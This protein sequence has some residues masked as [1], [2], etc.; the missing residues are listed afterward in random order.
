MP[1]VKLE[2]P[3][4]APVQRV[5]DTVVDVEGYQEMMDHVRSVRLVE[6]LDDRVRHSE[7]SVLLKGSILEWLE[8]DRLD[9]EAHTIRFRQLSGDLEFFDGGWRLSPDGV[10]ATIVTFEVAFDIGIPSLASMLN[11][12]AERSLRENCVTMLQAIEVRAKER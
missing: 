10:N 12:V 2:I 1:E 8:E 4:E 5:W 3:V 9:P 7:W 6:Q 11:P